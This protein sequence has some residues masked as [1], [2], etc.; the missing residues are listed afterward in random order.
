MSTTNTI[1]YK[2]PLTVARLTATVTVTEDQLNGNSTKAVGDASLATVGDPRDTYKVKIVNKPLNDLS[3]DLALTDDMR[4]T[5]ASSESTG[6]VGTVVTKALGA[7][8][9][10]IG[11]AAAAALAAPEDVDKKYEEEHEDLAHLRNRYRTVLSELAEQLATISED[12][13]NP[14]ADDRPRLMASLK[15]LRSVRADVEA[16]LARLDKHFEAWRATKLTTRTELRTSDLP[17]DILPATTDGTLA[18]A[19]LSDKCA[20]AWTELGVMIT[21]DAIEPSPTATAP[22]DKDEGIWVRVPR[23]VIW[24]LWARDVDGDNEKAHLVREGT[25]VLVDKNCKH[26]FVSFR[27]SWWARRSIKVEFSDAGILKKFETAATS[28]AAAAATALGEASG[29]ISAGLE[30]A[31]KIGSTWQGL[32]DSTSERRLT[33]LKTQVELKE[34]EI[35]AAGLAATEAQSAELERLK[36]EVAINE[37]HADLD[38]ATLEA[39][40]LQREKVLLDARREESVARRQLQ[41]ESELAEMRLE[42][43]RLKAQWE[44]DNPDK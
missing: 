37:A 4:L 18:W 7:A 31:S 6:Q 13:A 12:I 10:I 33:Q 22:G 14:N 17:T 42:I 40:S 23:P 15:L 29:A 43:E 3:V 35:K 25:A 20:A 28:S 19:N 2:L 36:Q 27:R 24:R 41:A 5:S 39:A 11:I 8:A 16:E 21:M 1:E 30:N 44:K 9:T 34:Q 26:E 38:P 32:R